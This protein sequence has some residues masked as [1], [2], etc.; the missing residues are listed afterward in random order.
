MEVCTRLK[1]GCSVHV[2]PSGL[3]TFI[4]FCAIAELA[5]AI[6]AAATKSFFMPTSSQMLR[7]WTTKYGRGGT[8]RRQ[9]ETLVRLRGGLEPAIVNQVRIGSNASVSRC[10]RFV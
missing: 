7:S 3:T 5:N 4:A 9:A 1:I 6:N 10:P 8:A 2:I